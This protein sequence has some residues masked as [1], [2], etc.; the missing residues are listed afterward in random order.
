M[1]N[2]F[3]KQIIVTGK[4]QGVFYRQSTLE[5]ANEFNITGT[6]KNTKDGQSVEIFATGSPEKLQAFTDWCRVGSGKS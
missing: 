2:Q 1:N 6:V 3:T 5:K 4:V